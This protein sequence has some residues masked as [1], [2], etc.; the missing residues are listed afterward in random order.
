MAG[1]SKFDDHDR[2]RVANALALN[3]GNI[4]R[5]ARDTG[6]A[7]STVRDWKREW[8]KNG[9]PQ[10]IVLAQTDENEKFVKDAVRVR[11]KYLSKL[12]E[13]VDSADKVRDV[14]TV[15]GILDDKVTRAKG[16]PTSRT[17]T[18][19]PSINVGLDEMKAALIGWA[20]GVQSAS[21][22]RRQD[23][24]EVEAVEE[25]ADPALP[26]PDKE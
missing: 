4:K 18:S 23:I 26:P 16:L 20:A 21:A 13:L 25:Q 24:I 11:D 12:E 14:A 22:E 3:D 9:V 8:E 19:G 15:I 7:E 10:E 2:A 6:I 17:E 5:T 1:R